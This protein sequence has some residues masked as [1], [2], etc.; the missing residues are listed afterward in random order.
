MKVNKV[1][2]SYNNGGGDL[3][4]SAEPLWLSKASAVAIEQ[5]AVE[6][7]SQGC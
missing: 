6:G 2:E 1:W 3:Q 5:S 7:G 4:S